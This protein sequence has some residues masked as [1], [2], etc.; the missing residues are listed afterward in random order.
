MTLV[1]YEPK[2]KEQLANLLLDYFDEVH[3]DDAIGDLSTAL[4]MIDNL[5]R[6]N[7]IYVIEDNNTITA[8]LVASILN[9]FNMTKDIISCDYMYIAPAYRGTKAVMLLYGLIGKMCNELQLDATGTTFHTSSNI[10]N[11]KRV[12]GDPIATTYRFQLDKQQKHSSRY[13]SKMME[14]F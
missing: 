4:A 13:I 14:Q 10:S 2:H 6:T 8:F 3:G 9:Q 1:I 5:T 12:E 11:N 7:T